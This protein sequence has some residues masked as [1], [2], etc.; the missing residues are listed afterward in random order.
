MYNYT[1][2]D[3]ETFQR[4]FAKYTSGGYIVDLSSYNQSIE[5]LDSLEQ[6]DWIDKNTIAIFITFTV[7]FTF[8]LNAYL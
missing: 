6:N 5:L 2:G 3:G 7:N 8:H 1:K 4:I